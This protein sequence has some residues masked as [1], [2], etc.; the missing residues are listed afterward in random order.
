MPPSTKVLPNV[1]SKPLGLD[2]AQ[3]EI[4]TQMAE[5]ERTLR[6][7]CAEDIS[8]AP[9]SFPP[10]EERDKTP[11]AESATTSGDVEATATIPST[12]ETEPLFLAENRFK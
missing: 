5:I 7:R 6:Q 10:K 2:I 11:P 3:N 1:I 12:G 4:D 9:Q 8:A